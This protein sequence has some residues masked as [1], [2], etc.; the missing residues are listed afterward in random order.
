MSMV[1][2]RRF[3][4]GVFAA[5][6]VAFVGLYVAALFYLMDESTYDMWG[7]VIVGPILFL[8]SLP[9]FV[10]QAKR[11]K[12]PRIFW[13]L[14]VALAV[15]MLFSL[16][17]YH[18]AF[19]IVGKA[20]AVAYDR[21][22]SEIALRFLDGTIDPQL[23]TLLD[24][25]FIRFFTGLIYTVIRPSVRAGLHLRVAGLLGPTSSTGVRPGHSPTEPTELR[26]VAVLPASILFWPSSI[27]KESWMM[28]AGIAAFGAAKASGRVL[29]GVLVS[30]IGIGPPRSRP[31]PTAVMG[32]GLVVGD[33]PAAERPPS[34]S[35]G[36]SPRS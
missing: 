11:E 10:R 1:E 12:Q 36:R 3:S 23:N 25:N 16:F 32:L 8:V 6:G 2:E 13:F 26:A 18:H 24:T 4:N 29:P 22:G 27:G 17:R 19:N 33:P 15:K 31:A 30:G 34:A 14:V 28:L 35:C 20:D 21:I 7:A 9:A 5:A